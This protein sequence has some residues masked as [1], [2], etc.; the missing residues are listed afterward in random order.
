M[1]LLLSGTATHGKNG[2]YSSWSVCRT[3]AVGKQLCRKV[4]FSV[5]QMVFLQLLLVSRARVMR[6][7]QELEFMHQVLAY[8][9]NWVSRWKFRHIPGPP[10]SLLLGN[11][12]TIMQKQ[13]F[14]AHADWSAQ[15]GDVCR[16]FMVRRPIVLLTGNMPPALP[17]WTDLVDISRALS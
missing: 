15:Y 11:M 10:P 17:C 16:Y 14:R 12:K 5:L 6:T 3:A 8:C 7:C 1:T 2:E 13:M 4:N 9:G